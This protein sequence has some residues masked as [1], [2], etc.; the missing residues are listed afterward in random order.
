MTRVR[1]RDEPA[2]V[3]IFLDGL[4]IPALQG[5]SVAAALLRGGNR[6][7]RWTARAGQP[8]GLFCV[9]GSCYECLISIDGHPS[10][11]ACIA[12]VRDGMRVTRR[13]SERGP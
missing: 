4:R 2:Q 11:R 12:E 10:E 9:M 1:R 7:L 5:E 3:S 8:R 6:V 13:G